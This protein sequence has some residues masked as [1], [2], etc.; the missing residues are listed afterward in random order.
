MTRGV[1]LAAGIVLCGALAPGCKHSSPKSFHARAHE[2]CAGYREKLKEKR[3]SERTELRQTIDVLRSQ[4][5][6]L[7]QLRPP[8]S[9]STTYRRWLA[10]FDLLAH[11]LEREDVVLR[12][13]E[14]RVLAALRREKLPTRKLTSDELRHPTEA[15]LSRTLAPLPEWHAF[16]RDMNAILRESKPHWLAV[17]RLGRQLQLQ[18]C[19]T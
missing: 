12:R 3:V 6:D 4:V 13:D 2:I 8:P 7:R 19:V 9:E 11:D 18:D 15:I 10:A 16:V 17:M 1:V 5:R 14:A